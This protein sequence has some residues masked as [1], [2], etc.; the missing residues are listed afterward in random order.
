[1]SLDANVLDAVRTELERRGVTI[2]DGRWAI[3]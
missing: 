1:M 2:R 3:A